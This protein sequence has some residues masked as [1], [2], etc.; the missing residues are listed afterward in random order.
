[1]HTRLISIQ[2][3]YAWLCLF[4]DIFAVNATNT[5]HTADPPRG[6]EL[7]HQIGCVAC[8]DPQP[9]YHPPW[10]DA[11]Q[12]LPSIT[13]PGVPI[14]TAGFASSKALAAYLLKPESPTMPD[15]GLSTM[16]A[17]ALAAYLYPRFKK[18][19]PIKFERANLHDPNVER[20][21][22]LLRCVACHSRGN[23]GGPEPGRAVYFSSFASVDFGDEGRLPPTL[24]GVGR[25]LKLNALEKIIRGQGAAR[26]YMA[27][28]MPDFGAGQAA[29]LSEALIRA[30]GGMK[31]RER[32]I[33]FYGRNMYGRQLMD[34]SSA[35]SKGCITCH[36]L[37]GRRSLGIPAMDLALSPARLQP[38]WFQ[39]Y[40]LRPQRFRPGTRMPPLFDPETVA[41]GRKAGTPY[42]EIA[43][44]WTYL[45]EIDQSPLPKGMEKQDLFE[46]I[47]KDRPIVFRTFM[48]QVGMSAIAVGFPEGIHAAFDAERCQWRIIWKGRF[49]DAEP[50]WL[51]RFAPPARPLGAAVK[52]LDLPV[53]QDAVFKGYT[54]DEQGIPS[55]LY[56]SN[57]QLMTDRL[58]PDGQ[59]T[60]L[61]IVDSESGD[62]PRREK[63]TW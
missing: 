38:Q 61:R 57:G 42:P 29:W 52:R 24:T 20:R 58:V 9:D 6:I 63:I 55:F 49:L 1:M 23:R 27:T 37:N 32:D 3:V 60:F 34:A 13:S 62:N 7:Y 48:D 11:N 36:N 40:L 44:I 31:I 50:T 43:H 56:Q 47:P 26:P 8:H 18:Q 22:N 5:V 16:E 53:P 45:K 12:E 15:M 46:L 4:G 39:D 17:D 10:I 41:R 2:I 54:L 59:G 14:S 25:K 35:N 28:R 51:D 33:F 21:L 19:A 30:D